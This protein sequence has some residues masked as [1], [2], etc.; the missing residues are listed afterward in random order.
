M[1]K[2]DTNIYDSISVGSFSCMDLPE[3]EFPEYPENLI[4]DKDAGNQVKEE[5]KSTSSNKA[6]SDTKKN[7]T[8]KEKSS[9]IDNSQ[10]DGIVRL[11]VSVKKSTHRK[12]MTVAKVLNM[13]YDEFITYLFEQC[14]EKL[15]KEVSDRLKNII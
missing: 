14:E 7:T 15:R 11:S 6:K 13:S 12:I 2:D 3:D 9:R 10:S 5:G 1:P 4:E 8:N